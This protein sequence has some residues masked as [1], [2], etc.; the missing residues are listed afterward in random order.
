MAGAPRDRIPADE[1]FYA[2]G[3][4]SIRGYSYQSVGPLVGGEPLGGRSLLELSLELRFKM[5]E[6]I[7]VVTFLDGGNTFESEFPDF[8]ESLVWGT[9]VGL[10][11][12][13]SFG[14]FRLDVGFPLDRRDEIDDAFQVYLSIGQAF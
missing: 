3:G 12:Y 8:S 11:F 5:T 9:G 10:R 7:G 14:P 4:G 13:T 6:S 1:R 2:G